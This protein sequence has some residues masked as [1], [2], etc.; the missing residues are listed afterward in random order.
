MIV[1]ST[2]WISAIYKR[3]HAR[4]L[5]PSIF[6]EKE[7]N[8]KLS[9]LLNGL[10][11]SD[12]VIKPMISAGSFGLKR[13]KSDSVEAGSFLTQLRSKGFPFEFLGDTYIIPPSDVIV[14]RFVPDILNGE[15]SLL[16]FGGKYSYAVIKKAKAGDFRSHPIW[17]ASVEKHMPSVDELRR[18]R[19]NRGQ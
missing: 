15:V 4:A 17:G 16:Y 6:V 5:P 8:E 18:A 10:D 11:W 14:Q 9:H 12:I 3:V 1:G 7:S 19:A 2:L 13:L